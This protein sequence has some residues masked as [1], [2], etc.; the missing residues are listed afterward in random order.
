MVHEAQRKLV[1]KVAAAA[2]GL[3]APPAKYVL[4]EED[5]PTDGVVATELEFPTAD[6]RRLADPGDAEEASKLRSALRSWGLFAVSGHGIPGALLDDL[7][8]ASREFFY[9]PSDEKLRHSNVVKVGSGGERFQPEGYGVDRVDTDE[10]V[11]DWCDRLYLQVE[12]AGERRL[13]FLPARPPSLQALLHEFTARSGERVARPLL[14]AMGRALGFREGVFADRLGG[15][16]A[17]TYARFTY[18][19]PCPRRT[20]STG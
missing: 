17:A 3:G 19:P 16:R 9:L 18:Y 10:Q 14:A 12:P 5:R 2:A 15:E 11:L 1:Q 8:A 6:L 4:R 20:S 7:L 13:Q